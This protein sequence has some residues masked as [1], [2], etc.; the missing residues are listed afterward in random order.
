MNGN[1]DALRLGL[2]VLSSGDSVSFLGIPSKKVILDIVKEIICKGIT[3]KGI[4]GRKVF[5]TWYQ[6]ENFLLR[7]G[8]LIEPIL[9]HLL[10]MKDIEKGFSLMENNRAAK[11][12]L[13]VN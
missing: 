5:G 4:T 9:T 6:C 11:V 7:N 3:I 13:N 12:L 1:T 2:D 8:K 10:E